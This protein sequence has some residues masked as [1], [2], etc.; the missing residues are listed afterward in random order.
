MYNTYEI[1]IKYE[2]INYSID[3]NDIDIVKGTV[4]IYL[5]FC[6]IVCV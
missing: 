2:P 5:I 6:G 3:W 1:C 4:Q